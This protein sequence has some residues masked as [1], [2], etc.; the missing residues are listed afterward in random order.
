MCHIAAAFALFLLSVCAVGAEIP[1][2]PPIFRSHKVN[3]EGN[4]RQRSII[5]RRTTEITIDV[6]PG[7]GYCP[8]N[9]WCCPL[10][11]ECCNAGK[12]YRDNIRM[13]DSADYW[14]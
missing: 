8:D 5:L 4:L 12:S 9:G 10:G 3:G 7:Y 6:D 14:K 2:Q 11:G 13:D 1:L